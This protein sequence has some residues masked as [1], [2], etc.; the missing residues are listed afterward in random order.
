[1]V[2]WVL[3]NP[4]SPLPSS[5][6]YRTVLR[7]VRVNRTAADANVTALAGAR[8]KSAT[9]P[10]LW[11]GNRPGLVVLGRISEIELL[12]FNAESLG[13]SS[14]L[15]RW[16]CQ[17]AQGHSSARLFDRSCLQ[18]I[19]SSSPLRSHII[20]SVPRPVKDVCPSPV[21]LCAPRTRLSLHCR[22]E[23]HHVSR[24]S[25]TAPLPCRT[26]CK[27]DCII[28]RKCTR[29]SCARFWD[30]AEIVVAIGALVGSSLMRRYLPA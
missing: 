26:S 24:G 18:Q 25:G 3:P 13:F 16:V 2:F 5:I 28:H 9:I 10:V 17:R 12:P 6:Y 30:T 22:M 7:H 15:G 21:S 8:T 27:V 14:L 4:P 1:M 29:E 20:A 23:I 11:P 19:L